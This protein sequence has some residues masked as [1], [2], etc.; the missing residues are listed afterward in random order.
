MM[1][2]YPSL[3]KNQNGAVLIVALVFLVV[4]T[5][6]GITAMR[7]STIEERM[8]SN[9]QFRNQAFQITQSELRGQ[10]RTLNN[11]ELQPL[12]TALGISELEKDPTLIKVLPK[13]AKETIPM[14]KVMPL[15]TSNEQRIKRSDLRQVTEPGICT[16]EINQGTS[17]KY[18]CIEFE[19]SALAT[20]GTCPDANDLKCKPN[21]D[22]AMGFTR[23]VYQ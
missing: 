15:T 13:S 7:F 5:V 16:D 1:R 9:I 22:Q 20:F 19:L 10:L 12:L 18:A 21:S 2:H 6:A 23:P 3:N 17:L 8:A 14:A 11:D 4:L